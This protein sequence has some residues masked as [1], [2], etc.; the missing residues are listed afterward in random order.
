MSTIDIERCERAMKEVNVRGVPNTPD[1]KKLI[2]LAIGAIQENPADALKAEYFGIKNYA[3]FGDQRSDHRYGMGPTHG[4][5]VF[6][7]GRNRKHEGVLTVDDCV[8]LLECVRDFGFHE[9]HDQNSRRDIR[10]NLV[11]AIRSY[12][13]AQSE[14]GLIH[15]I[16]SSRVVETHDAA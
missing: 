1:R 10:V 6:E 5:I 15:S 2:E 11:D 13:K 16:I 9:L 4:S 8:Y 12:R 14:A 7:I 3:H